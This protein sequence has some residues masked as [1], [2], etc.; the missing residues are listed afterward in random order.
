MR[1]LIFG[2]RGMLGRAVAEE[3]TRRGWATLALGHAEADITDAAAV[4]ARVREFAPAV[5][6][7]CAAFT[8]V[9]AC[10]TQ[11]DHA[12]AVNGEAVGNVAAAA[13]AAGA[14]LVHVSTDYVFDGRDPVPY[15]EEDHTAPLSVYGASKLRGEELALEYDGALVVRTSW[16]FGPGGPNFVLTMLRLMREDK[17]PLRVVND[18]VGCPTYT[19][20]L[21][22]ALC[23]LL[24][25]KARG[26]VHYRNGE[27]AS[28][29]QFTRAIVR[30]WDPNVKVQPIRSVDF[31]R[32][33]P[34]PPYSVLAVDRV[35][36]LLGRQ[37]EH[38]KR[39]LYDYLAGI[40]T[41]R[42]DRH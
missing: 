17:V 21:A 33:A 30:R 3:T 9:D 5:V 4:E 26:L 42:F 18:Q 22:A 23:D 15:E 27:A 1:S 16:L 37:V 38:W 13:R 34:R 20:F 39:G 11:R 24:A 28:W 14:T 31:P 8:A 2:G 29:W 41:G 12:F 32:P 25:V 36:T 40:S 7:N 35:E 19:P 10:E 6:W